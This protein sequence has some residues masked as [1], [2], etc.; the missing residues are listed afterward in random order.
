MR[1]YRSRILIAFVV[2][3]AA[4]IFIPLFVPWTPINCGY[5][6]V[7]IRT[8]RTRSSWYLAGCKVYQRVNASALSRALPREM[9]NGAKPEWKTVNT[10]SPG[11]GYSPHHRFHGALHQIRTL[12]RLWQD[13]K[14]DESG[15]RQ[16]ASH[17]LALWQF[18]G[19]YYEPGHYIDGLRGL[20]DARE[21]GP[22]LRTIG[23]LNMPEEHAEGDHLVLTVFYP[24][25]KPLERVRG[26]RE[27]SGQF[28]KHGTRETWHPD[29][30]REHYQHFDRGMPQGWGFDWDWDGNLTC[31][32]K[33]NRIDIVEYKYQN[34][35]SHPAY[36]EARRLIA[37]GPDDRMDGPEAPEKVIPDERSFPG[38]PPRRAP[39]SP[40]PADGG[41]ADKSIIDDAVQV[42]L[43]DLDAGRDDG[44][45]KVQPPA[46]AV[47]G[48][49]IDA[50]TKRGI[51]RFRVIPGVQ[52]SSEVTEVNWQSHSI[53]T[54]RGG[55]FDLPPDARAWPN[56]RYR[57]EAEGYRPS[58]SRIVKSSEG[59][60]KLTFVMQADAGISAVVRAP[61]GAP[62]AGS[63]ATWMTYSR[64]AT[65]HGATI[66]VSID[67]RR[68]ATVVTADAAGRFR[69]PPECD[70][71]TI[72][73]AHDRGYAEIRPADL[74]SS[75]VVTLRRWG[76][77]EGRVFAGTKPVAG[78]TI[79]VQR[80]GH[81]SGDSPR[82]FWMNEVI[83]D[84]DGRFVC[85][86]VVAGELFVD[87]VFPTSNGQGA[88]DG[89]TTTIEVRE[90]QVTRFI[91]GGPGRTL[92][93]RFEAPKDLGLPI[94]WSKVRVDLGLKAPH[95]GFPGDET[96]W[97]NYR[98]FLNTEE[99]RTYNRYNLPVGR[100]GSFR[101]ESVPPG[102][103]QLMITIDGPAVG[104]PA[105]TR[106]EYAAGGAEIE[107]NPVVN[108]RGEEPQSFGTIA[109]QKLERLTN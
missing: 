75:G 31:I 89:L 12:E 61:D 23:T 85:D 78:Q 48:L 69:L 100:D 60:V 56:M 92:V 74:I 4:L 10:I 44:A 96:V 97:K 67:E 47:H 68:G 18:Y 20:S 55:R 84:A 11:L 90:G 98:T 109:L 91:L 102:D 72:V 54:H 3:V 39:A 43:D 108:G 80:C 45:V 14:V 35:E 65:G 83:T 5:D 2:L 81:P 29:G 7:D 37:T 70:P 16:M 25:G 62:A 24:D 58:V 15:R 26:Y 59:E 77:V 17:V 42:P 13:A 33:H 19:G 93:G 105:E 106:I 82:A 46:L 22:L 104:K 6:E 40:R 88:V 34:L 52:Q 73:I 57:V 94:D 79:W 49:V 86:R 27:A 28:V 63:Q 30:K 107:V 36:A 1:R 99:G 38:Q 71:G 76:R 101:I 53:T 66:T 51:A 64:E 95:I 50:A 103:Y 21:R 41:E 87:R 9:V 8:G 32:H